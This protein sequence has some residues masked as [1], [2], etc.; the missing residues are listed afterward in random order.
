MPAHAIITMAVS[1][2]LAGSPATGPATRSS[3]AL[4]PAP[5]SASHLA[6]AA[7]LNALTQTLAS[8]NL[9]VAFSYDLNG[10]RTSQSS[11]APVATGAK[12]GDSTFPCFFWSAN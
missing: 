11:Q 2:A 1:A 4:D 12:W 10:N 7:A 9:C 6:T 3:P 5:V 8:Q